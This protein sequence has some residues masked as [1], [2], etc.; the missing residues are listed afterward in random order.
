MKPIS[1]GAAALVLATGTVSAVQAPARAADPAYAYTCPTGYYS[2]QY[3]S[4]GV[5]FGRAC[6]PDPA[7]SGPRY[8]F[9]VALLTV[10]LLSG[11]REYIDVTL[12]CDELQSA[13]PD[14][15]ASRCD[16]VDADLTPRATTKA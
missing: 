15:I 7:G 13:D 14:V 6:I 2:E 11:D 16:F 10:G 3:T 4:E 12:K 1:M 9:H 5:F 8:T